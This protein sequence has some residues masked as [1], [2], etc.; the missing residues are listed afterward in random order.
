[1]AARP[2]AIGGVKFA[3]GDGL[4][5]KSEDGDFALGFAFRFQLL[6]TLLDHEPVTGKTEQSTQV[7]RARVQLGGYAF[8]KHNKFKLELAVSPSDVDLKNQ[9]VR[10]SPLLEAYTEFDQLRDLT[11]RAGQY[12]VPFD[13]MRV[14]SD[15]VRQLVD[16][17]AVTGE[18]S[19]DRDIGV[20]L[21]S[22]DLFG[23]GA[24]RYHAGVFSGEGRNSSDPT[25]FGMLYVGRVEVLP[26]GLYDDY[27]EGDFQR[28][29]PR[30]S[31]GGAYAH[32]EN[33]KKD[34]GTTG[35][36]P[37]DAGTTDFDMM[38]ADASFKLRGF[39]ALGG[40]YWREG[41][42]TS[43]SLVDAKGAPI[44]DD[45]GKAI[46][47]SASRDGTGIV[48]QAGFL[49]P[50][51]S[52]EVAGRYASQSGRTVALHDGLKD[53]SELGGGVSYYFA[54][55]QLKLQSDY[56]RIY[57]KGGFSDGENQ[58]RVQLQLVL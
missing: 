53:T 39:S 31:I 58:V 8:G 28:T 10:T 16:Y 57:T 20:E 22:N 19:L 3:P 45:K 9:T 11:V 51:T 55:H 24:L 46:T 18:F 47:T 44:L 6:Y 52:F 40:F 35:N 2:V 33:G 7:R 27:T 13:R 29:G 37:A 26:L 41:H 12:K 50:R 48:A 21:K 30:V 36:V 43:G 25:D 54:Q 23:L 42:R 5:I 32:L 1:M 17:S 15:M 34:R 14:A 38:V 56:F 49:F 4:S